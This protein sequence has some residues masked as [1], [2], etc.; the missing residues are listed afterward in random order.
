MLV[1]YVRH[2]QSLLKDTVMLRILSLGVTDTHRLR[3]EQGG[4]FTA[5]EVTPVVKSWDSAVG[6]WYKQWVNQT[7]S[8]GISMT[9][10]L[11]PD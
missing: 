1:V 4:G 11:C 7:H 5:V 3:A 10:S 9:S 6:R 2:W 8:Y